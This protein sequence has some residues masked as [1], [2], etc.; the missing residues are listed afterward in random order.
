MTREQS[1]EGMQRWGSLS[2]EGL[3][4]KERRGREADGETGLADWA[5]RLASYA[6]S[7]W[8]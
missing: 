8:S 7:R 1:S 3:G 6:M 5:G 2:N 4:E